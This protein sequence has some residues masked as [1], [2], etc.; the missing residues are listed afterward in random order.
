MIPRPQQLKDTDSRRILLVDDDE[1]F[2]LLM[3]HNLERSGYT[4]DSAGDAIAMR[5][6]LRQED[7]AVVLL[8]VNLP[9][10]DGVALLPELAELSPTTKIIMVSGHGTTEMAI[11][12][13]RAGAYDFLTKPL[14]FD[15]C[16]VSVRNA[17]HLA[18]SERENEM[19]RQVA[20]DR[21]RLGS[22]IGAAP[23]M[24]LVYQIIN[25]VARSD[26]SVLVTGETGT[27]KELVAAELHRLSDRSRRDMVTVNCAA[28][29]ADLI[30]SEMFGHVKGSFTGATQDK[31]GAAERADNSSLFLDEIA[32]LDAGLQAKLLR[33]LQDKRVTRVGGT[34]TKT[35]DVRI[36]AATNCTPEKAVS[37]GKLRQDL[38]YRINVVHIHLP[39]LRERRSDI[40]LLAQAF[41]MES[42]PANQ[43]SF[44]SIE[45]PALRLL[46]DADWPGNVRQLRNVI[47]ETVL[48][49]CGETVTA[50]MLPRAVAQS[51]K[52]HARQRLLTD[53][54]GG[55]SHIH[56]LWVQ[57]KTAIQH[58][59][60]A[61]S[62]NVAMAAEKL[63]ISRATMYRKIRQ[64]GLSPSG[65]G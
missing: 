53:S 59:L 46:M 6:A 20:T 48:M 30:E 34:Q 17:V 44:R 55:R 33:F 52:C 11:D 49:N 9:D 29:P 60:L 26:V 36:M 5:R 7:Y 45:G 15:R 8:D 23:G 40:P 54:N 31:I 41:L 10:A 3:R 18:A 12:A 21:Q 58:A 13:V 57:E 56:A 2:C 39:P 63:E 38:L 19:L 22:M 1:R 50:D 61:F 65:D 32:E 16:C 28:I 27:G 37:S 43:K 47:T 24:Q 62:G 51:A 14:N 42:A 64:Y 35:T 25:N 4:V